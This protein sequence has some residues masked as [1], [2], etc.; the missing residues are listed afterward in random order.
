VCSLAFNILSAQLPKP[1]REPPT[2]NAK[3]EEILKGHFSPPKKCKIQD[4]AESG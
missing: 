2:R 4:L 1:L 3:R